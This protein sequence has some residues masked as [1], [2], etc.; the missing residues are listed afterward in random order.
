MNVFGFGD[1]NLYRKAKAF[2][3]APLGF[4][5]YLRVCV[6]LFI[7]INYIFFLLMIIVVRH[8]QCS[9]FF[10]SFFLGIGVT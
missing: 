5:G 7:T 3:G 4:M 9:S 1:M 10:F 2:R 6:R 8:T